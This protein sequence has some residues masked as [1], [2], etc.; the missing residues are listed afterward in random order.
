MLKLLSPTAHLL[1]H[2]RML[3]KNYSFKRSG[4][5]TCRWSHMW[6]LY[7]STLIC[8]GEINLKVSSLP[9]L[10]RTFSAKMQLNWW[11]L[12]CEFSAHRGIGESSE[13]C[14]VKEDNC[15]HFDVNLY[16]SKRDVEKEGFVS[17]CFDISTTVSLLNSLW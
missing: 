11:K 14:W 6:F 17:K 3:C 13:T 12:E 1:G 4:A 10:R 8:V 2:S 15:L 9:G 5:A 16:V 7:E